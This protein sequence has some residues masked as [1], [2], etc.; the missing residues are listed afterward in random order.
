[1]T[2]NSAAEQLLA[3]P[4]MTVS[5]R[6]VFGIDSDLEVPAF[7]EANEHVPDLDQDYL[8]DRETTLAILAGF[9]KNRRVIVTGYH[10]TGPSTAT[11]A[12]SISSAR[13]RS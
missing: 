6:Q 7:S 8:F 12:A 13:T 10:G 9:A 4:D 3:V 11:S 5:A 1:M 2:M